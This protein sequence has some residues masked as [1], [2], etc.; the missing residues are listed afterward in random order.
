MKAALLAAILATT[1]MPAKPSCYA[2]YKGS[3]V[4]KNGVVT[5][6]IDFSKVYKHCPKQHQ[7]IKKGF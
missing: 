6:L 2:M 7:P 5:I 4:E 3:S 1:P